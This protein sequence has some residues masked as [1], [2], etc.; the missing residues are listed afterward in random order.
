MILKEIQRITSEGDKDAAEHLVER[1]ATY[2][3]KDLHEEALSRWGK[4]NLKPY[5]AF[6]NPSISADGKASYP[7]DFLDQQYRYS[8]EFATL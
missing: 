2:V 1:Y 6:I 7:D 5:S 8:K 3:N 4:Y